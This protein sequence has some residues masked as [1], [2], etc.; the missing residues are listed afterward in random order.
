MIQ[1]S[2]SETAIPMPPLRS[3][4]LHTMTVLPY[5]IAYHYGNDEDPQFVSSHQLCGRYFRFI[6][7]ETHFTFLKN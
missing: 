2:K 3:D 4:E 5:L 7:S 6:L 1:P